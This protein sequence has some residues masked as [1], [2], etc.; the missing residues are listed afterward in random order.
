MYYNES[1]S[2]MRRVDRVLTQIDGLSYESKS[3][4]EDLRQELDDARSA[5]E[6]LKR[7]IEDLESAE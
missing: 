3:L 2:E 4:I 7:Q 6:E 5:I 1:H